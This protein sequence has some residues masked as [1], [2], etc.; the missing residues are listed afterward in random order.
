MRIV[1]FVVGVVGVERIADCRGCGGRSGVEE[2][3]GG[4][5]TVDAEG[6]E[7]EG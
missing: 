5:E 4:V 2:G 3:G 6:G 1:W 7:G